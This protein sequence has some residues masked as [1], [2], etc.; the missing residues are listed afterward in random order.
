MGVPSGEGAGE[1]LGN[2]LRRFALNSEEETGTLN[3]EEHSQ[4]CDMFRINWI[5]EIR[6]SQG[7]EPR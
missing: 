4:P 1:V 3:L 5:I 6:A 7:T 2:R